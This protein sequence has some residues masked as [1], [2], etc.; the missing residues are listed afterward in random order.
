MVQ[1]P[2]VIIRDLQELIEALDRR[3]PQLQR[4]GEAAILNAATQ[5]RRQAHERIAELETRSAAR[6]GDPPVH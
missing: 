5:L 4:S 3:Y 2:R 1:D 6:A